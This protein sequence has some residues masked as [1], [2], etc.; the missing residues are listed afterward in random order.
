[1]L[2]PKITAILAF[3]ALTAPMSLPAT[4]PVGPSAHEAEA[5][6]FSAR[7][8]LRRAKHQLA[9]S[10]MLQPIGTYVGE[11]QEKWQF[12]SDHLPIALSF[13]GHHFASWNVLDADYMDWVIEKNSQGLS[14]SLIADEH[15]Y[16]GDSKLTIRDRHIADLIL[17]MVSHPTHPRSVLSLQ[18][19][20]KP[21]LS[22]LRSR[23]PAH[24][25]ILSEN[26]GEAMI[27]DKRY[28]EVVDA[29]EVS[30]I[31]ADFPN[32]TLQDI[33]LRRLS[34]GREM[35][36]VSAHLPG[37]PTKPGRLEFAQYLQRTFDPNMTTLAM[38]DMNFNEIQMSDA[39]RGAFENRSPFSIY[40]PYP[41]NISPNIFV[42]KVIDHFFVYSP[43]QSQVIVSD[44]DQI[45]ADLSS[46]VALLQGE[47]ISSATSF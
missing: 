1:M 16:I 11:L 5:G 23:L 37:D 41:T 36:L 27:I 46:T 33:T 24:F 44:P 17:E 8:S 28:F 40:S 9:S 34:D 3:S 29:K 25:E 45:V 21:F 15:V 43:N 39:M 47:K 2:D 42:S 38:G 30:G 31:F 35:R 12:P 4:S 22:E 7:T 13:E 19:S 32:R 10:S 14:R 18:E 26:N 6:A 20:S